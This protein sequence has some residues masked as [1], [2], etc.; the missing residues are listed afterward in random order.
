MNSTKNIFLEDSRKEQITLLLSLISLST[1]LLEDD[2]FISE[3]SI[4]HIVYGKMTLV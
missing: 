2:G 4:A 3:A 1:I